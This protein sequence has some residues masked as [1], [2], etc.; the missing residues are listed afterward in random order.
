MA[1]DIIWTTGM[2]YADLTAP[3]RTACEQGRAV[4]WATQSGTCL[5]FAELDGT[6]VRIRHGTNPQRGDGRALV[7]LAPF[8]ATSCGC[9]DGG[10]YRSTP[11]TLVAALDAPHEVD[12]VED[13]MPLGRWGPPGGAA[14]VPPG[15]P[16]GPC[17]AYHCCVRLA[18][19]AQP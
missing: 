19:G 15:H 3:I 13:R 4:L 8:F 17:P 6:L 9:G 14:E 10:G 18:A 11:P 12:S 2:G 7:V 16:A 5:V 1:V